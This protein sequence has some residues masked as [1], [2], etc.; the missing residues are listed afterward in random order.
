LRRA[1]DGRLAARTPAL[2]REIAEAVRALARDPRSRPRAMILSRDPWLDMLLMPANRRSISAGPPPAL[3]AYIHGDA[4]SAADR[5]EQLAELFGL[6]PSESRLALA[7]SRGMTIAE[8]AAELGLTIETARTYSK[9][10]Y[11]KT[12]ARG[13]P[14][15]V[16]FIHRSVLAIV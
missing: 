13:Q 16:R 9:K 7:L 11:A 12:G 3:I 1:G 15:L 5:C 6:L 8:A 2:D 4:W 10:I 14:D